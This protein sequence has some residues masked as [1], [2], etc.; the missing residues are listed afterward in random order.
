VFGSN[1]VVVK[2]VGF[3]TRERQH[4]LGVRGKIAHVLERIMPS[5]R[6]RRCQRFPE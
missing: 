4:L 5:V 3:L 2:A 1:E 6:R